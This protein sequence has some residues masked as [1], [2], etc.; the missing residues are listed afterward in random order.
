[1][2]DA[3][4]LNAALNLLYEVW[5]DNKRNLILS[6]AI[7]EIETYMSIKNIDRIEILGIKEEK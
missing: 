6:G 3:E 5:L 1:M 4:K 2:T 7:G